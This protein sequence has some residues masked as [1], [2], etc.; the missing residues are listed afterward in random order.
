MEIERKFLLNKLPD[1]LETYEKID[2]E[3]AYISTEPVIRV[4]KKVSAKSEKYI[5]TVKSTGLMSRQEFELDMEE[6]AYNNLIHKADGNIISKSRYLIPLEEG[7]TLELDV[8]HGIFDGLVMG[9]IEFPDEETAKKYTPPEFISEE[10][11]FDTRFH[12]ST[13]SSMSKEDI[14]NLMLWIHK[15]NR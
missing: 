9:E 2:L 4:R 3:Q 5:L 12:N 10:V 6:K 7:L 11:T 1:N 13:M 15:N 8:F 14:S